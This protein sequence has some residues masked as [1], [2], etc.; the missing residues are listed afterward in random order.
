[1][2]TF[3]F[4]ITL[5]GLNIALANTPNLYLCHKTNNKKFVVT[6]LPGV[7]PESQHR[8]FIVDDH[9]PVVEAKD[10][11][12]EQLSVLGRMISAVLPSGSES[13]VSARVYMLVVPDIILGDKEVVR[14]TTK[15]IKGTTVNYTSG[16][17][18]LQQIDE[19][20]DMNCRAANSK[21][22]E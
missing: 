9:E 2:K 22:P 16:A 18:V 17:N 12:V 7:S 13:E 4:L 11:I 14:F 1:M 8:L 6:F 21:A 19:V 10:P 3:G 15:L 20:Y 5:L